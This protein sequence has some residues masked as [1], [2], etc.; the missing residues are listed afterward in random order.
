MDAIEGSLP[1]IIL[2]LGVLIPSQKRLVKV[3]LLEI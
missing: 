2:I 3:A 1:D